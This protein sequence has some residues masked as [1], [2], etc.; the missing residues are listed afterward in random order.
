[1]C[2]FV[3]CDQEYTSP[4]VAGRVLLSSQSV[5][6]MSFSAV[7]VLLEFLR[8]LRFGYNHC[9]S[10]LIFVIGEQILAVVMKVPPWTPL[11][12]VLQTFTTIPETRPKLEIF[13]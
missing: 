6:V 9:S 8:Q 13:Q 10:S 1:M 12:T 2:L 11:I 4:R 7:C 3:P 5:A